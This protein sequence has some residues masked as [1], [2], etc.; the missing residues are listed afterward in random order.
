VLPILVHYTGAFQVF[1]AYASLPLA[2]GAI[3]LMLTAPQMGSLDPIQSQTENLTLAYGGLV[4][5]GLVWH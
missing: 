1:V 5:V 2:A 3:K 4:S